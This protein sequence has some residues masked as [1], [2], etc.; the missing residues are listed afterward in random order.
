MK[1]TAPY[2][3]TLD[4]QFQPFH[5]Q[6]SSSSLESSCSSIV[7][8]GWLQAK[9]HGVRAAAELPSFPLAKRRAMF[10]AFGTWQRSSTWQQHEYFR[11]A[12]S[13]RTYGAVR[14]KLVQEPKLWISRCGAPRS[15]TI[16]SFKLSV[17]ECSGAPLHSFFTLFSFISDALCCKYVKSHVMRCIV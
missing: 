17:P 12:W 6:Q 7:R 5:I 4:T 10:N 3:C 2:D 11:V 9:A 8:A 16:T 1:H 15:W 14:I 13:L